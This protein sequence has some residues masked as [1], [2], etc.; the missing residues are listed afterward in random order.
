MVII[1][2]P[3]VGILKTRGLSIKVKGAEFKDVWSKFTFEL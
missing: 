1:F 2:F 3:R